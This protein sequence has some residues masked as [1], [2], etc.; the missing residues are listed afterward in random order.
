MTT[1]RIKTGIFRDFDKEAAIAYKLN[2]GDSSEIETIA[3]FSKY[4]NEVLFKLPQIIESELEMR[5]V[6]QKANQ[7][8]TIAKLIDYSKAR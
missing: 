1:D 5:I 2:L 6:K 3:N 7:N 4:L 8:E